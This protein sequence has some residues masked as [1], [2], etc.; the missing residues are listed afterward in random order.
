MLETGLLSVVDLTDIQ[1]SNYVLKLS[2]GTFVKAIHTRSE[3]LQHHT[4]V[5]KKLAGEK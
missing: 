3:S 4:N 2:L 1:R 5:F